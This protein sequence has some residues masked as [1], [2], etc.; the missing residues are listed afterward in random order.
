[1]KLKAQGHERH[2]PIGQRMLAEIKAFLDRL[3]DIVVCLVFV[4]LDDNLSIGSLVRKPQSFDANRNSIRR[5]CPEHKTWI[6]QVIEFVGC[7]WI[8]FAQSPMKDH[9][10]EKSFELFFEL[11]W[12]ASGIKLQRAVFLVVSKDNLES[13]S[14]RCY[15][16]DTFLIVHLHSLD[17]VVRVSKE[18]MD[19]PAFDPLDGAVS[20]SS[21][22]TK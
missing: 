17:K 3:V 8:E 10:C 19:A 6:L 11:L 20:T 12:Q 1:M 14:K 15:R 4:D 16:Q 13:L 5:I 2:V 7:I 18:V 9:T 22:G 21:L